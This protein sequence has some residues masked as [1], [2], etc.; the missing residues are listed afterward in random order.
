MKP[1]F[2]ALFSLLSLSYLPR[3]ECRAA[4]SFADLLKLAPGDANAILVVDVAAILQS[5]LAVREHWLEK[6][7]SDYTA[8]A[9]G[10][11]PTVSKLVI[12]GQY[13]PSSLSNVW[14]IA[15]AGLKQDQ[16]PA[17]IAR[18]EAGTPD[19]VAGHSVVLSPRDV[20]FVAFEPRVVGALRPANRQQL[21]RWLQT[22]ARTSQSRLSPYLQEA[23]AGLGKTSQAVLAFDTGDVFDPEGMRHLL[24]KAKCLAGTKADVEQ[25]T[26]ALTGLKGVKFTLRLD[27]AIHGE[28]QLNFDGPPTALTGVAKPLVLEAMDAIGASIDEINRWSLKPQGNSIILA[29]DLSAVSARQLL[30]SF[31]LQSAAPDTPPQISATQLQQDPKALP[32]LRYFRSATSILKDLKEQKSK[33]FKQLAH[34]YRQAA[35]RMDQLP[36]LNV[37]QE[38]VKFGTDVSVT[39]RGLANLAQGTATQNKYIEKSASEGTVTTSGGYG[40]YG[41]GYYFPEVQKV[42]NFA[43]VNNLQALSTAQ[44]FQ[45]RTQTWTNIDTATSQIRQKM[46]GRYRMEF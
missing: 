44:E 13:N 35:E 8:G 32:S 16:S 39:L 3:I 18:G 24:K 36:I 26:R 14:E 27:Q 17:Q 11:P 30:S 22:T 9:V 34:F 21:A 6:H 12:A 31:S 46:V 40:G 20:Y 5:P 4:D 38:L 7:Q 10:I 28:L 19:K 15:L 33:T 29:G 23:A 1:T 45:I 25:L 42:N 37:D 43:Q 41:Y 2:L